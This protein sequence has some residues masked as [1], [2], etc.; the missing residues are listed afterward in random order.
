MPIP[1]FARLIG[2]SVQAVHRYVGDE[3][4]P[5]R[6]VMERIRAATKGNAIERLPM[7][8]PDNTWIISRI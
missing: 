8:P 1:T 7:M 2:V 5:G 4:V 6:E 3:R